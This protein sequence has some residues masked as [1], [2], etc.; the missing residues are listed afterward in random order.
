MHKNIS[1]S[2]R[3]CQVWE[4][5]NWG[6]MSGAERLRLGSG[7]WWCSRVK[8]EAGI[9]CGLLPCWEVGIKGLSRFGR[10]WLLPEH[11]IYSLGSKESFVRLAQSCPKSQGQAAGRLNR[12]RN[13]LVAGL[14]LVFLFKAI[15]IPT[16]FSGIVQWWQWQKYSI[17]NFSCS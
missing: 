5:W 6:L 9:L 10:L 11:C 13:G 7:P 15:S 8:A 1:S 16:D 3:K 17:S 4:L 2:S 12:L 14:S